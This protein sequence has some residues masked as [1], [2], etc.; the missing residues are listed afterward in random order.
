MIRAALRSGQAQTGLPGADVNRSGELE[1]FVLV[2]ERGSLSAAARRLGVSPSA[3]S[4]IMSRLEARLG[5]QL[6]QRSTRRLQLTAE[7]AQF[8]ERGKRVLA[9]LDEVEL[10]VAGQGE[11]RG[12]VRISASSSTG[13][14]LLVPLVCR[15]LERHPGLSL[16]LY[17]TDYVVD[18]VE[19]GVD[20]AIR[21]GRLPSSDVVARL[22]GRTGQVIV[23]SPAYLAAR[24]VPRHPDE[25]AAHVRLGWN[26]PREV[27]DWP[28]E[29]DGRRVHVDIGQVIRLNDGEVMRKLALQGAGLARLSVYHAWEDL[30][31]GNLVPVL[32]P[33]NTGEL[34]PIHAVY[35]GRPDRLPPRTR[36]VLDFLQA[37]VDLRY[38][39]RPPVL[40]PRT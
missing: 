17:F 31:A 35:L 21:W 34:E 7:G 30:R 18:L 10:A 33:Y 29:V 38:A 5:V 3:V 1:V 9:D 4:K 23:G 24:G 39:E 12:R 32:E 19:A 11:P 6:L 25:L 36:A 16:D 22:L 20:I 27:P 15:L 28:F 2:A 26:Y 8:Y 14:K 37:E 13:Q 40:V